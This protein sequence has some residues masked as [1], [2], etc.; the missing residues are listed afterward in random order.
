MFLNKPWHPTLLTRIMGHA[1]RSMEQLIDTM[2]TVTPDYTKSTAVD[3]LLYNSSQIT[4][5]G[6][7]LNWEGLF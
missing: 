1:G 4:V 7:R 2:S 5:T 3:I 6:S